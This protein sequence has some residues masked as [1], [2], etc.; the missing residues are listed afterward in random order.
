[1]VLSCL[2]EVLDVLATGSIPTLHLPWISA[3]TSSICF[4]AFLDKLQ[5]NGIFILSKKYPFSSLIAIFMINST[6]Q[7]I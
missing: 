3:I 5:I 6:E 4:S 2:R 7:K 1:M